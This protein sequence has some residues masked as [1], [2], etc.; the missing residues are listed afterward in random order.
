[1][2]FVTIPLTIMESAGRLRV[3]DITCHGRHVRDTVAQ[4]F[5]RACRWEHGQA[6]R[7]ARPRRIATV[8]GES[9]AMTMHTTFE[10]H[11]TPH[12]EEATVI[13]GLSESEA[14]ATADARHGVVV[15]RLMPLDDVD[16]LTTASLN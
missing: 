3:S 14:R 16:A 10:V 15:E 1:M 9:T 8:I 13:T 4:P 12:P 11:L 6:R 2:F 5:S 7:S